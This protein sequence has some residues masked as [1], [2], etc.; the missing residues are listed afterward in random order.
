[1]GGGGCQPAQ[2]TCEYDLHMH[3]YLHATVQFYECSGWFVFH[4]PFPQKPLIP[5]LAVSCYVFLLQ[6]LLVLVVEPS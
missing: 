3:V 1:M 6:L 4:S 2:R 5:G